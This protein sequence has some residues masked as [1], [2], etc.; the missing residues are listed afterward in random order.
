MV[1]PT[2]SAAIAV[3]GNKRWTLVGMGELVHS[4]RGLVFRPPLGDCA[5]R[6]RDLA[7]S[8]AASFSTGRNREARR[9]PSGERWSPARPAV[10]TTLLRGGKH[11][12]RGAAA[13]EAATAARCMAP[14]HDGGPAACSRSSWLGAQ[15]EE[16]PPSLPMPLIGNLRMGFTRM[17]LRGDGSGA[18]RH[19]GETSWGR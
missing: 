10:L 18:V 13:T 14:I 17:G 19:D 7:S 12:P 9:G 6:P 1:W 16:S 3:A 15:P 8:S 4:G 11:Q 2:P 5:R